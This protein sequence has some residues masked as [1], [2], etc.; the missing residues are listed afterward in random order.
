[1]SNHAEHVTESVAEA[2]DPDRKWQSQ[3][4]FRTAS[5]ILAGLFVFLLLTAVAVIIWGLPALTF[6][7][8]GATL[9]VFV[10]LIAYAAGF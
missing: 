2:L 3:A 5:R 8:M 4:E 1:M 7:A 6:V 9:V 10:I